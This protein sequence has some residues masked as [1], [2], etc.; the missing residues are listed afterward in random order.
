MKK[1]APTTDT[2]F[3]HHKDSIFSLKSKV[4]SI[5]NSGER[6]TAKELNRRLYFNDAR[7]VISTLRQEHFPICDYRLLDGSKVYFLK[8]DNQLNLFEEL[9]GGQND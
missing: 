8:P 5:L 1:S 7:K 2:P 6:V 3:Q 4:L 9:K